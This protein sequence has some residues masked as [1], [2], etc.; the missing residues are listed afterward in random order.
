MIYSF[1]DS[2]T[3]P[4]VVGIAKRKEAGAVLFDELSGIMGYWEPKHGEDGETGVGSVILT[5]V[6]QMRLARDQFLTQTFAR[7]N[8]PFIYYTGAVWNKAGAVTN[9]ESWFKYLSEFKDRLATP[10]KVDI[11]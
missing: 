3:L 10:I 8:E 1:K 7:N 2:S 4:V 9:K 5:P 6:T 11:Q